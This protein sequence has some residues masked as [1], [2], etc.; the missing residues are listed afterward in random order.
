M[1]VC[2]NFQGNASNS[3]WYI[4]AWNKVKYGWTDQQRDIVI[5]RPCMAWQKQYFNH[6]EIVQKP[7]E[8]LLIFCCSF[9]LSPGLSHRTNWEETPPHIWFFC[10]GR[11][12]QPTYSVPQ[13]PGKPRFL[14]FTDLI[15]DICC[16][17]KVAQCTRVF[18]PA[19]RIS[20]LNKWYN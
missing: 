11:V 14:L 2:T 18:S 10:H 6:T 12:L 8:M 4:L 7:L 20:T 3:C 13:F 16:K 5:H 15:L 9:V 17:R 19:A 1:N